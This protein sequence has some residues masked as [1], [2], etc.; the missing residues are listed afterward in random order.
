VVQ[1]GQTPFSY[2]IYY[3]REFTRRKGEVLVIQSKCH[4]RDKRVPHPPAKVDDFCFLR[5]Q[6][7]SAKTSLG[8]EVVNAFLEEAV[9]A[10]LIRR[11]P[12][13]IGAGRVAVRDRLRQMLREDQA[14]P[15]TQRQHCLITRKEFD[16]LCTNVGGVSDK[17]ALLDFLL[18]NGVVFYR[19]GLFGGRIVLDQNWALEAIY[20]LFD[21]NEILPRL[22]GCGRF[23]RK[24][25]ETLI[26]TKY[27]PDQQQ[28][29]LEMMENCGICFRLRKLPHDP[30]VS[31]EKE[32]KE[33]EYLA[34]ELLPKWS[35]VQELLFGRLRDDPPH[36]EAT[37]RYAFLHEGVLRGYLSKLGNHAKDAAI[38]WKYGC[39]FFEQTTRSQVLIESQWED[40]ESEFGAGTIRFRAWGERADELIESL[41]QDL[42]KLL[43]GQPPE[44]K[45]IINAKGVILSYAPVEPDISRLGNLEI[46]T[47][48]ELPKKS[49]PEIFVSYAWGDDSS[50]EAR[51]RTEVVDRL[52]E[53]LDKD[54]WHILRDSN[55]LRSGELISG[56][57]K[58]IG[59]ADHVIVV[60]S[61]KYLRSTYCMTELHSIYQQSVGEKEDFLRRIIPLVLADA[62]FDDL[63]QKDAYAEH[64]MTQFKTMDQYLRRLSMQQ[65][66]SRVALDD[67]RR[68]KEM[69]KWY[70]DVNDMLAYV[71]DVLTPRGFENIV[72]YDFA[73]LRQM[74]SRRR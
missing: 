67:F 24:E 25:L 47:H 21:R 3:V 35:D 65:K 7:V 20:S 57:M 69:Q 26:W 43:V 52:C 23:T 56:F 28:V 4:T 55:A 16:N 54:G 36:A 74:L 29:F 73:R 15:P 61:D 59:L 53:T 8:L 44:I 64:W 39:W 34:P 51:K 22:R 70:L 2:W 46:P 37:A 62:K 13:P 31:D 17:D 49:T 71:N 33:W 72:K 14:L 19:S 68:Y 9:R 48:P 38:Y 5:C 1:S 11:P 30:S 45:R 6:E 12:P 63:K 40:A 50:E 27:T 60:L 42:Q 10:C 66:L 18:L 58:R 32:E 41:L